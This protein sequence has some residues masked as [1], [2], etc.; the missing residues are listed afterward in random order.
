MRVV[1]VG[2]ER[3]F[4]VRSRAATAPALA[5]AIRFARNGYS[6][7]ERVVAIVSATRSASGS[8]ARGAI[9]SWSATVGGV[10]MKPSDD[11]SGKAVKIGANGEARVSFTVPSSSGGESYADEG[12]LTVTVQDDADV[13]SITATLPLVASIIPHLAVLGESGDVLAG[14]AQRIYV[15][16]QTR[17]RLPLDFS[18]NI[19]EHCELTPTKTKI[20][21][22]IVTV[23][24]GRGRSSLWTPR[25]VCA[26]TLV[27]MRPAG[28]RDPIPI[29]VVS[30]PSAK[31]AGLRTA[32]GPVPLILRAMEDTFAH[33]GDE[34]RARLK[35]SLASNSP[36]ETFAKLTISKRDLLVAATDTIKLEQDARVKDSDGHFTSWKPTQVSIALPTLTAESSTGLARDVAAASAAGGIFRVTAYSFVRESLS[37]GARRRKAAQPLDV[38]GRAVRAYSHAMGT[39]STSHLGCADEGDGAVAGADGLRWDVNHSAASSNDTR[40]GCRRIVTKECARVGMA[41]GVSG[42]M[43]HGWWIPTAERLVY[44]EPAR[45]LHIQLETFDVH[46]AGLTNPTHARAVELGL[47]AA[48]GAMHSEAQEVDSDSALKRSANAAGESESVT[49]PGARVTVRVRARDALS[50]EPVV[51][52]LIGLS[53]TDVS[54]VNAVDRRRLQP[55]LRSAALLEA[56]VAS[57]EDATAFDDD[58]GF[59]DGSPSLPAL[60]LAIER[61]KTAANSNAMLGPLLLRAKSAAVKA[62]GDVAAASQLVARL[63]LA[64]RI[65]LLLA[66][67]AWRRFA[68][69]APRCFGAPTALGASLN[70]TLYDRVLG[71]NPQWKR[72]AERRVFTQSSFLP[73]MRAMKMMQRGGACAN[74]LLLHF[75]PPSL[76]FSAL[77]NFHQLLRRCTEDDGLWCRRTGDDDDGRRNDGRR[78]CCC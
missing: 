14:I 63:A 13:G 16:A 5:L 72:F 67:Q 43:V 9:L 8:A 37:E 6:A 27:V 34:R 17:A 52:A 69:D 11:S 4:S 2:G 36:V 10:A 33:S 3:R 35:F 30:A 76:T 44:V 77:F 31:D 71:V 21:G 47:T 32:R 23:H 29:A 38:C 62:H 60:R 70:R 7:G 73:E 48:A 56:E 22:T 68:F 45:S 41:N 20:V 1:V 66:T 75:P 39:A 57:L 74:E 40:W 65:D 55:S 61:I 18:A 19:A 64:E 15:E 46:D 25:A 42:S 58:I 78:W 12:T 24:E 59:A 53:V 50:G 51:G 26:Y 54:A 49:S 28:I